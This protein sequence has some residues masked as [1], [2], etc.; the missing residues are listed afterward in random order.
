[1][2]IPLELQRSVA[3]IFGPG[4]SIMQG[5]EKLGEGGLINT[6]ILWA[7]VIACVVMIFLSAKTDL[8]TFSPLKEK[9]KPVHKQKH[10]RKNLSHNDPQ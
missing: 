7:I 10:L 5:L 6:S 8:L 4:G 2:A 9:R 3:G 1:M